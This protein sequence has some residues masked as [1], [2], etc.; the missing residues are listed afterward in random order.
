MFVAQALLNVGVASG[1][2]WLAAGSLFAHTTLS[3]VIVDN[4][5]KALSSTAATTLSFLVLHYLVFPENSER[6]SR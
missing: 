1:L 6:V 3:P 5:A 4:L 2:L